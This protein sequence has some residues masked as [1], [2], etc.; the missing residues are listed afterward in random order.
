MYVHPWSVTAYIPPWELVRPCVQARSDLS[1]CTTVPR[2]SDKSCAPC[3]RRTW[4]QSRPGT[5]TECRPLL[6]PGYAAGRRDRH[7]RPS[8]LPPSQPP[9]AAPVSNVQYHHTNTVYVLYIRLSVNLFRPHLRNPGVCKYTY[10][11]GSYREAVCKVC[12]C[13]NI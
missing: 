10:N 2:A 8:A 1:I 3:D 11:G 4:P 5:T 9:S 13:I 12:T 7:G 6:G